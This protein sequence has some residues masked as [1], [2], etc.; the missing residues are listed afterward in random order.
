[1]YVTVHFRHDL[2]NLSDIQ[3]ADNITTL[4][5]ACQNSELV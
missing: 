3:N 1:M 5:T 2:L 4:R